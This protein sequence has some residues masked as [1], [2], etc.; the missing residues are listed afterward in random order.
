[1]KQ[2]LDGERRV[3]VGGAENAGGVVDSVVQ[4]HC[5]RV[6]LDALGQSSHKVHH[7]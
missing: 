6:L 2:V 7:P 1:M 3:Q 4:L 5:S